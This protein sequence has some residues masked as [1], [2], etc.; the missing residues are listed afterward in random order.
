MCVAE[1]SCTNHAWTA[2]GIAP[3][4]GEVV[5][6]KMSVHHQQMFPLPASLH[7]QEDGSRRFLRQFTSLPL[8]ERDTAMCE[9]VI[10][11]EDTL[12]MMKWIESESYALYVK[13]WHR[14][15]R[16]TARKLVH[17]S[18]GGLRPGWQVVWTLRG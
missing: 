12:P 16:A 15:L 11:P 10:R 9:I 4:S 2:K 14:R 3:R 5:P 18:S 1:T 7:L 13:G 17:D 6:L 8:T